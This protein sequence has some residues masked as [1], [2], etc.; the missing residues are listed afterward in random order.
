MFSFTS[1]QLHVRH[2]VASSYD[3]P[4]IVIKFDA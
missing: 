3:A 2:N 1:R 4:E